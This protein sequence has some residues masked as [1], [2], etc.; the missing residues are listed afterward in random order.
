[1]NSIRNKF[2][3]AASVPVLCLLMVFLTVPVFSLTA[4][5][6]APDAAASSITPGA[7]DAA[8]SSAAPIRRPIRIGYM[9]YGSFIEQDEDG[10]YTGFGVEFLSDIAEYTGWT[11]EY[12]YDTWPNLLRRVEEHDIDFLGTPQKTPE[13]EKIY[14]FADISSGVEQTIIYTRIGNNDI[15]YND[16]QAMDNR[17]VGLL[18]DSY[19][20]AFFIEY[21]KK[22]GFTFIPVFYESDEDMKKD[23]KNGKIDLVAGGSL[24]L[25]TD[26]KV[27]GK[28]GADPFYWMTYK[29]NDEVLSQLND[30]IYQITNEDPYYSS[31]LMNKYYGNSVV[32][33]QPQ[34]TREEARFIALNHRIRIGIYTDI[35]PLCRMNKETGNAEGILV[36]IMNMIAEETGFSVTYVPIEL[37]DSPKDA[38]LSDQFDV[39]LPFSVT[40]YAPDPVILTSEPFFEST[41]VPI[42]RSNETFSRDAS[43]NVA[44]IR[45]YLAPVRLLRSVISNY[46]LVYFE[47]MED[48]FNAVR[49]GKADMYFSDAYVAAYRLKSPFFGNLEEDFGHTAGRLY[50]FAAPRTRRI[51]IDVMNTTIRAL[52]SSRLNDILATHTYGSNYKYSLVERLYNSMAFLV[53]AAV[54]FLLVMS[55]LLILI[56]T[57]K[58]AY[59]AMSVK[60]REL[61]IANSTRQT[62]LSNMSHEIRTPLNGIKG[63]LD[64]L[65][66][67]GNYD[68]ETCHLLRMSAI[69]ADHLSTLVNDI[70]D[71]SKLE[72]G[73]LDLKNAYF[74][75][76][77]FI[78]NLVSIVQ[79]LA[80]ARYILFNIHKELNGCDE[81]FG[82]RNRLAQVAIN[83][84]SNSIKYTPEHGQVDFTCT[85][86]PLDDT[87]A[88]VRIIVRDNGIGMSEEFLKKAFE[89]FVQEKTSDTRNG[90][91]LGLSI[92]KALVTLMNGSFELDSRLGEGTTAVISLKTSWRRRTEQR[93]LPNENEVL[94]ETAPGAAPGTDTDTNPDT[95]RD[96]AR[97]TAPGNDTGTAPGAA[98]ASPGKPEEARANVPAKI[99]ADVP[100]RPASGM[101]LLLTEDNDINR[102]IARF[103]AERFGFTVDEAVNG[104]EAVKM[105]A[106]STPGYYKIILMDIMMPVMDGLEATKKIRTM[107]RP[108]AETVYIVAMTANAYSQDI[109]RSIKSGMDTHLSKP[110][111]EA[112]LH[113]IF[114]DVISRAGES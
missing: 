1:M 98:P 100:A 51:L 18:K 99:S 73:K 84:L 26:L 43:C 30:A 69:S 31:K 70:L 103:Q 3:T 71:M 63:S 78:D 24:A 89:P 55:F 7:S 106:E 41:M 35:Y 60:N 66:S 57:Q 97:G 6:G 42:I 16:F 65:L 29:G 74:D 88:I 34:F 52:D 102:D 113:Q 47:T 19:Q 85:A 20:T 48:C 86:E 104:E 59:Q 10:N 56:R 76:D 5:A 107:D 83:L 64:L 45:N 9:D 79:P 61:E 17:R 101:H 92:A 72:S 4:V 68:S 54:I 38:L 39:F 50:C 53:A 2:I 112:D 82:D 11:Y 27:V 22:H 75:A 33:S 93:A 94:R 37:T 32:T 77:E 12:V 87:S 108:D 28:E 90:T 105:F 67:N 44:V 15:Y 80:S 110:F 46:S 13:R 81:I 25:S 96:T 58:K 111:R 14:D 114:R 49:S 95:T 62:F 21:A 109:N 91:G 40:N 8:A 23:L 36:D